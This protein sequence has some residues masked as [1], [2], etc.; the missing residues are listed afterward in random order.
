MRGWFS[1]RREAACLCAGVVLGVVLVLAIHPVPSH[2]LAVP[3]GLPPVS[4]MSGAAAS[5]SIDSGEHPDLPRH[6]RQH[7]VAR[8]AAVWQRTAAEYGAPDVS[9][10]RARGLLY[11][12]DS[13]AL[14]NLAAAVATWPHGLRT[15]RA[16]RDIFHRWAEVEP[17]AALAQ[18][19]ALDPSGS[20]MAVFEAMH[21]FV[22]GEPVQAAAYFAAPPSAGDQGG[23]R[24]LG[25]RRLMLNLALAGWAEQDG[26]AAVAFLDTLPTGTLCPGPAYSLAAEWARQAPAAALNWATQLPPGEPRA[27]A[28]DGVIATWTE[29]NPQAAANYVLG[30]SADPNQ[31]ALVGAFAT[32]WAARDLPAAARWVA[33]QS[34]AVQANAAAAIASPWAANDPASAALWANQLSGDARSAAYAAV[35]T[36]WYDEDPTAAQAWLNGL[37]ADGARD[38]AI[39]SYLDDYRNN[40][41]PVEKIAWASQISDEQKRDEITVKILNAWLSNSSQAARQWIGQANLPAMVTSQLKNG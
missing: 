11:Q 12:L 10:A 15:T 7:L 31:G 24:S 27:N 19:Q 21:G 41:P 16:I 8:N 33:G 38:A 14:R 18:A 2:D 13:K 34:D 28:M 3:E 36:T 26:Q 35:A 32:Q 40:A 4:T 30:A 17:L 39:G 23:M 22:E 6:D 9:L 25:D 29:T 1:W 37:P 5:T 20:E